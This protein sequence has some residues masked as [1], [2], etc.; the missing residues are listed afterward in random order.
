MYDII[1]MDLDN[2]ILDFNVAE[3]DSFKEVIK[4][5]G[6]TYTNELLQ[7]YKKINQAL[8]H[9]LEQGKISKEIVLNTR[10]SEF[11]KLYD[12]QV[13]GEEIEKKYRFYLDNS[14]ALIP[15]AE[16]TL[17][18]L[19]A[20]GKKIY[21]ASNGAYSTQIKRLSKAGIINLF[22]GHFISETIKYEKPSPYFF[23]FCI[24]NLAGVSKSSILMV[25]D[26]PTSDVQGAINSGIDS[27]FYQ[28]DR[29][30][31]C[32]YSKHTI[33]DISELLNIV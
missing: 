26:S 11:F 9:K 23:D 13:D 18:K 7:Q 22:D 12:I 27:C 4:E 28:Y 24:K 19:R 15:N 3:K 30:T 16:D 21:S 25:G 33:C 31:T 6:L 32:T 17:I 20:M 14:S 2:T 29:T 10:F 1:L 5:T 8:W